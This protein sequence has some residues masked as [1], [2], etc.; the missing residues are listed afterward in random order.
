[1]KELM[2]QKKLTLTNEVHQKSVI[3]VVIGILKMLVLSMNHM[4]VMLVMV[5]Q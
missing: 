4:F 1:M 3:F 5:Y 2:S